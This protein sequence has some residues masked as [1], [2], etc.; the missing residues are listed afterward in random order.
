GVDVGDPD[1]WS[2]GEVDLRIL[3][4]RHASD[5]VSVGAPA[6][7]V[8]P[9]RNVVTEVGAAVGAALD[10]VRAH[11]GTDGRAWILVEDEGDVV[12]VT[13]R[14]DG[15]GMAP[16]RLA[17]AEAAGRLGVVQAIRGRIRDLKGTATITS[18]PGAG[19]EVELRVPRQQVRSQ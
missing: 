17:E 19:T 11:A 15:I 16:S 2:G 6:T 18:T 12:T 14:D 5:V 1:G 10:N 7:E 3:I 13:V 9:P 4:G 8:M